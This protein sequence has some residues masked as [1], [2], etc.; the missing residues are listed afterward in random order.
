VELKNLFSL[1]EHLWQL[2]E[3]LLKPEIRISPANIENLLADDFFEFGSS[4]NVWY[5]KDCIGEGSIW[6]F[7]D[8]RRSTYLSSYVDNTSLKGG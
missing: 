2:E 1:N 5:K 6:R 8:G 4:G 7:R 3:Q